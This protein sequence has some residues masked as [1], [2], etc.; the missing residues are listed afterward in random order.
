T[1][2]PEFSINS[3]SP[4][5]PKVKINSQIYPSQAASLKVRDFFGRGSLVLVGHNDSYICSRGV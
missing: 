5:F 4:L 1:N 3:I 2:S